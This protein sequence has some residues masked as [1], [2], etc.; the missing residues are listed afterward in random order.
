[1][2]R[3]CCGLLLL[4][5]LPSMA[6]T[7][8]RTNVVLIMVDD[9]GYE[10]VG[11]NGGTSYRTPNLDRMAAT[12]ARG[13][14]CY[15]QPLC[16]PTRVQLMTGQY[17]VRNY[18]HF[19]RLETS[20]TTF[21]QLF[22]RA[23]YATGI[24]GKWQLGVEEGLPA[25]FGFDRYCLWHYFRR[26]PRYANPG[27]DIDG[28]QVDFSNGEYGPDIVNDYAQKFIVDNKD[29][30]FFL[31]YPMMLTH[32]P[33]Q[34]TPDSADWDPKA[35]GERVNQARRHFADMVAY[36]D[37]LIGGIVKTLADHGLSER[38][39]VIV[40]GD[41]GTKR[42][43]PSQMGEHTVLGG[44]GTARETGMHVP[45]LAH[46]PGTIRPGTVIEDLVDSTD[47]LP[48][49]CEAAGVTVPTDLPIDGRSFLP[50]LKGQRG[51]P[52]EWIYCWYSRA[53]GPQATREFAM[54]KKFKLWTDGRLYD[55]SNDIAE[56]HPLDTQTLSNEAAQAQK[57]LRAVLDR[58]RDARPAAIASQ[59]EESGDGSLP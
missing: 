58:Y 29:R 36:T 19:G 8:E 16:T 12:G 31:Y 52:R 59:T 26:A 32:N 23:G 9:W 54:N 5:G 34:P 30:P 28:K 45:L 42:D 41:N 51:N 18:I 7:A 48:T 3:L 22:K 55:L 47:F 6:A 53:G 33:F 14:R 40:L 1:M 43:V 46:W 35:I 37:K 38:T 57:Q 13:T 24:A 2:I 39:L 10:C 17:N 49:I 50:P 4:L 25:H 20:Q 56:Q 11:A 21:G 15:V 44:K 27:L